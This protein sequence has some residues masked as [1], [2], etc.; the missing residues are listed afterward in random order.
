MICIANTPCIC[1]LS[2]CDDMESSDC[3]WKLNFILDWFLLSTD[4]S[5]SQENWLDENSNAKQGIG[6]KWHLLLSFNFKLV[7]CFFS[8]KKKS[9]IRIDIFSYHSSITSYYPS[10]DFALLFNTFFLYKYFYIANFF[11]SIH[12]L[13]SVFNYKMRKK[14]GGK[15]LCRSTHIPTTFFFLNKTNKNVK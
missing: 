11:L 4:R 12:S 13:R 3:R 14:G 2:V 1:V 5:V 6:E 9:I 7:E 10:D 8:Q 15:N